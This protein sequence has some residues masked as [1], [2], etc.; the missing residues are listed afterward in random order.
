MCVGK[1]LGG[2]WMGFMAWRYGRKIRNC[3]S[4]VLPPSDQLGKGNQVEAEL[5]HSANWGWDTATVL[6]VY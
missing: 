3:L 4:F 1:V 5:F 6:A 2:M